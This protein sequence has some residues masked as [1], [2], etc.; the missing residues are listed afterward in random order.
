MAQEELNAR[1]RGRG[2]CGD[3]ERVGKRT[4][5]WTDDKKRRRDAA[6]K[7]GFI[8]V[9][10]SSPTVVDVVDN[11]KGAKSPGKATP[12]A[13][14]KMASSNLCMGVVTLLS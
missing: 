13:E 7:A 12:G 8:S 3:D 4:R 2:H 11:G 1:P 6:V 14:T 5:W 9:L 10:R